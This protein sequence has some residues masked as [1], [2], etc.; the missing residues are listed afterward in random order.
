MTF[1]N[2]FSTGPGTKQSADICYD[3]G[4]KK[5]PESEA[6]DT[7]R[8]VLVSEWSCF[9]TLSVAWVLTAQDYFPPCT[10]VRNPANM[11]RRHKAQ[12][13]YSS[14]DSLIYLMLCPPIYLSVQFWFQFRSSRN[15]PHIFH[16]KKKIASMAL[17]R[18]GFL[19]MTNLLLWLRLAVMKQNND[20]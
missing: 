2:D 16:K 3:S 10:E 4:Q 20:D 1:G 13:S 14:K 17:P 19:T 5:H 6:E 7:D 9:H 18:S 11:T 8:N 15:H 12:T